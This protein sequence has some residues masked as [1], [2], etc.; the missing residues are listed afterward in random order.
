MK[1]TTSIE[2]K[3]PVL[4][5]Q[6]QYAALE[7]EIDAAIKEVLE[8]T[9]FI[10]GPTVR[11][12][13]QKVAVFCEC[14][15]GIGVA[16]GTDALRLALAALKVGPGD[17]VITT[18]FT[19]IATANTISHC[20]ATPVFVDIDPLTYNLDV[21]QL[22]AAVTPRTKAI[23]PVHL[24]GH[25][26]DMEPIMSL[27]EQHR[28]SVIEDCA[29]AIG[30][31]YKEQSV[32]SFGDAGCLSFYPTKNLGAYG[33]AGMVVTRDA[34]LAA[35]IDKL[36][37]QGGGKK[38]HA[39]LLGFNS[40]LDS[41][42]AA[43]LRVKLRY[44]NGWNESRR[45][46]AYYYN[47]LLAGLPVTTPYE[48][49]EVY[50][51]YHQYTIRAPERNALV[52]YLEGQGISTMVYYPVPLHRQRLYSELGYG[53]GSLPMSEAA[54][55]EV[56]SLPIFPELSPVQQERVAMAIRQFYNG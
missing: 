40:R 54:S 8:S 33:D 37:R 6:Q 35:G 4:D 46:I 7:Q 32:G 47:E 15:Y 2:E 5:L 14:D 26:V 56:L 52:A 42:Q 36:R 38:Y 55:D 34:E 18:P 25:P 28:L 3:I 48:A 19:F 16:S 1:T 31:R 12:L 17:E 51:V 11:D 10:L 41:L 44:L 45:K 49:P 24:Y 21:Q 23:V 27:A 30:A 22:A 39:E 43:I 50:H 20:G 53:E 9:Q 13:E 29:Q